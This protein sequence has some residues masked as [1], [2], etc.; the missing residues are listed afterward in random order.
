LQTGLY[1]RGIISYPRTENGLDLRPLVQQ[2]T[3]DTN[4]EGMLGPEGTRVFTSFQL[5]IIFPVP[6]YPSV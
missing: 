2:H 1:T 5:I 6:E 4:W 3:Q